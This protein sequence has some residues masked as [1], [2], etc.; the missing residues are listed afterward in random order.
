[1]GDSVQAGPLIY[2]VL[3]NDWRPELAG[4]KTPKD[5]F[6]VVRVSIRNTA[7]TE[8]A[9]PAFSL[10]SPTGSKYAE[11]TEGLEE[12]NDWLGLLRRI[13][14]NQ[15][16]SGLAVFDAP[17]GAYKL[18]ASDAGDITEERHAHIEIPVALE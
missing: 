9:A 16:H 8:V 11:V 2:K 3:E 12:L 5:R 4:G 14:P 17:V 15:T 7:G 13:P 18:V 10:L 1:M 6:L